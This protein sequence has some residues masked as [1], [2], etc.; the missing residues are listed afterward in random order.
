[1]MNFNAPY[2]REN[3]VDFLQYQFLPSDYQPNEQ[4]M[5]YAGGKSA[6]I[7]S[8]TELGYCESL[9][10][11]VLEVKHNS[12]N[13]ARVS[14]AKEIFSFLRDNAWYNCLVAFVPN[15]NR[16]VYRL[17]FIK[18]TP[19]LIN[20]KLDWEHSNPKRYS[21]LL[22]VGQHVKTPQ[23]YLANRVSSKE[24]LEECFSVE[25]LTKEF[26]SELYNWYL[27]A[28][29]ESVN[30]HYPNNACDPND[31]RDYLSEH[32]I[33][34]IT[35][36]MFVWFIKQKSFIPK[37][38]FDITALQNNILL[39][40]DPESYTQGNYYNAILQNLFFASLNKKI[41][42]RKFASGSREYGIK[43]LFRDNDG[44]KSSNTWFKITHDQVLKLFEPVP[45]LNGGL[46]ECLDK[47]KECDGDDSCD[48]KNTKILY[49]DGFSR[50]DMSKK[51][52]FIPNAI[53]FA[54]EHEVMLPQ[55]TK[56]KI[57]SGI[58]NIFQ[59]YNFTVEENTPNDVDVA[60]D[61]ELLGKVFENLL[62]A[63]NPETGESA[64][65]S[66][67]SF[68]TP[69]EIVD[70]MV[71]KSINAYLDT[72]LGK[73][74][75]SEDLKQALFDIKIIDPACGSG[76]FPM[77]ILNNIFNRLCDI[78]PTL[79]PY[80][81][82]LQ[83]IEKCIYGVDIQP[84]A[85][86]I[87][88]LRFFISLICEQKEKNTDPNTNYGIE[89]LPNLETKFVAA[90]TLVPIDKP[91]TVSFGDIEI[92]EVQTKL[93]NIR[94]MHFNAKTWAEKKR[95]RDID[96][97]LRKELLKILQSN[98]MD[99]PELREQA[100]NIAEWDPYNQNNA[101]KFFDPEW[102]FGIK[103]GFDIVIGNPP[104]VSNKKTDNIYSKIYGFSDD[105]YNYF[106]IRSID[107]CKTPG[108]ILSFIT[109]NTFLTL[110]SKHNIR[111]LLQTNKLLILND[112]G[113]GVF[114]GAVV[115]T[116]ISIVQKSIKHEKNYDMTY[117]DS[118]TD[119]SN[120]EQYIVPIKTFTDSINSVFFAPNQSNIQ[121]FNKYGNKLKALYDKY[122]PMISTSKNIEKHLPSIEAYRK[123]L[124]PGDITLMGLLT[125]GG[126]GLATANNGKYVAVLDGT[127]FAD[128]IRATRPKKLKEAYKKYKISELNNVQDFANFLYE[129]TEKEIS[130]L[131]DTLKEKYG[132]DIFGQG[133]LFRIITQ[134]DIADVDKLTQTEKENGIDSS[135]P[136]Y[137]VYDKG[138]KDGNRWYLDS[139]YYI[140][141]TK[142]NVHF[143]KANSGK[144]GNGM[145]VVRNSQF[146][147]NEGFCW[148]NV[149]MPT[150]DESKYI[151]CRLKA[152]SVNDVASMSLYNKYDNTNNA[153]F[154]ALLN[155]SFMYNYLKEFINNTVNL[156]INDFRQLPIII[157]TKDQL[158]EL[159]E[160]TMTAKKLRISG[161]NTTELQVL[162]QKLEVIVNKMYLS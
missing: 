131:F 117:I 31:D 34:L 112:L 138:D 86:Q 91:K 26:Y 17:S 81:T 63:Y 157:P 135:L 98:G 158:N 2:N 113:A 161:A 142:E 37:E 29:S 56:P 159:T 52:A 28:S 97:D 6:K 14:I 87:S 141:W 148:T 46:F 94:D 75:N 40:F 152:K 78:D 7:L 11:H 139:P 147:F 133:Y 151:K 45:F 39:D 115:N 3:L 54:P 125:D 120:P 103:K 140:S 154:V 9:N 70:Y 74:Y 88:K 105:L 89:Q 118:R 36:L 80:E 160:L 44:K 73:D 83:L 61:P 108:G 35:R 82:K 77:G 62:A 121:I 25:T 23:T 71:D 8:I 15:D 93:T 129:K 144:K 124:K 145:P 130:E 107:L 5:G 51:R 59:K 32:L 57:V 18:Q 19:K 65:K 72:K 102:M 27:W 104:Y 33:R 50:D 60:L 137:V 47:P 156:Q 41:T 99:T 134:S 153:Y 67:G 149:L 126:Q 95:C 132:R 24:E 64:R 49:F 66:S 21:F 1:M 127:K 22:G 69:R 143:L 122:W 128:N 58:I 55:E 136:H 10:L 150:N 84:I 76:A 4:D 68:Y 42:E 123:E 114:L 13:D 162:Q 106:F 90:N 12:S 116:V 92:E 110:E 79:D 146:Y 111:D 20:N 53:F 119:F 96:K 101:A 48:D 100:R 109:S 30:I 43:T 16:D 155:S 38:L 85:V